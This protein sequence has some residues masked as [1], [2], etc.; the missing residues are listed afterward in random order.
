MS[1]MAKRKIEKGEN[2]SSEMK[3]IAEELRTGKYNRYNWFKK[4]LE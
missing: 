1:K 2:V 4:D 3:E